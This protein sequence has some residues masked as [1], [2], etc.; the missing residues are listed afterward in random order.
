MSITLEQAKEVS[1]WDTVATITRIDQDAAKQRLSRR[2][3]ARGMELQRVVKRVAGEAVGMD[4]PEV[5]INGSYGHGGYASV[6]V[7]IK[8]GVSI[9]S[10][11]YVSTTPGEH[12]IEV[13]PAHFE[14]ACP[15]CGYEHRTQEATSDAL[16]WLADALAHCCYGPLD[17]AVAA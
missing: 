17:V 11:V 13:Y 9:V 7:A 4:A 10:T 16:T 5:Q 14:A 15:A 6:V 8:G 3:L 1:I 2:A 12:L